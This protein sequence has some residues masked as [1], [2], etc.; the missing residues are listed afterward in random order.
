MQNVADRRRGQKSWPRDLLVESLRAQFDARRQWDAGRRDVEGVIDVVVG[1]RLDR[2][3]ES[4]LEGAWRYVRSS[5]R[6][7]EIRHFFE[8]LEGLIWSHCQKCGR[9]RHFA[10]GSR[11]QGCSL[12]QG[13]VE[14]LDS[15]TGIKDCCQCLKDAVV[16]GGRIKSS[17]CAY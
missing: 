17:A 11:V 4:E 15:S 12:L 5:G 9:V 2:D 13:Q 10:Q 8:G 16:N 1:D 3:L 7:D 6:V 14:S